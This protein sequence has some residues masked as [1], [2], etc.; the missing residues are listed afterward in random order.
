[1]T[2]TILLVEDNPITT[3]LVRFALETQHF[4]VVGVGDGASAIRAFE[5][6]AVG[7]VLVDLLLPDMDGFELLARL[8][9]LRG[10]TEVPILAF[11]GLVSREIEE[12]M[13]AAGF[14]DVIPKPI[15]PSRFV[16]VVRAHLPP[17]PHAEAPQP[18]ARRLRIVIADDDAVQRKLVA[19]RLRR[20][21]Y[22][23]VATM[24]GEEALA[25]AKEL[26]PDAVVSDV[27]MPRLDGFGL[28]LAVR[29]DPEIASTPVVLVTNSYLESEDCELARRVGANDLVIRTPELTEVLATLS[30]TIAATTPV[31]VPVPIDPAIERERIQRMM[32]QLERQVALG[33]GSNQRTS[34]L[35]AELAVLTAIADA[36]A[37]Q[38]D[39][40]V[41][42]RQVLAACFDA[43]GVSLGALYLVEARKR[44]VL[45][46]GAPG[47]WTTAELEGFFGDRDLLD[48]AIQTQTLLIAPSTESGPRGRAV[49][50]RAH[51]KSLLAAPLANMGKPLG[52]LVM[53]SRTSSL[54]EAD[55]ITFARAVAAQISLVLALARAFEEKDASARESRSQATVL[56]SIL[57]SMGDGVLVAGKD[58]EITHWNAAADGILPMSPARDESWVHRGVFGGDK[59]TPVSPND[60]P[61]AKAMRGE[62]IN[63]FE[64]FVRRD[65][66]DGAW[67]SV[68]ARPMRDESGKTQGG[69][70]VFR[71]VTTE[72]AA[73]ARLLVTDRMASLGILAAGVGHEI[74]NPL[75]SILAN[76]EMA[77]K[78]MS[79]LV[80]DHS[81]LDFGQLPEELRDARDAAERLRHIVRDLK[82]FS[83]ADEETRGKVDVERV[84]ESSI[85]LVSAEVRHRAKLVRSFVRLPAVYA[86]ESRLGQVFVN[87]L[88]NAAHAIPEGRADRNEIRV[89][90]SVT[91]DERV[92]IAITDTGTGMP[93]DVVARIFTP[94][95]TTKPVGVGTG[96]G[97]AICHQL[98]AAIDGEITLDTAV[99]RG[100]TF[101]VTLPA[102]TAADA[103]RPAAVPN[104]TP[105]RRAHILVIDDDHLITT[106]VERM[107]GRE[108]DVVVVSDPHEARRRVASGERYDVLLC[109]LM[110]PTGTGM[111]LHAELVHIAPDQAHNM[112]FMTGGAFT[113][114]AREFLDEVP[115]PRMEK[116]F[117]IRNLR[118]MIHDRLSH[119][120]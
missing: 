9:L 58:G 73:N 46:F 120:E 67:F 35:T 87:L 101:Y 70:A 88:V 63:G 26:R 25:R 14:D 68:N 112:V 12:R 95:Y 17:D 2:A 107:L 66:T 4:T 56:R 62:S 11:T 65:A 61:L 43:G 33:A 20:A 82:L 13:S 50:E 79:D 91:A 60:F 109:D 5:D 103:G 38:R 51:V 98:V 92:R 119:R 111:D 102:M 59:V 36:V 31:V 53:V 21:G 42:L 6:H 54:D 7:L 24:D 47:A 18:A 114:R 84:L 10:G 8:R 3:K 76:L 64:L 39:V 93:P 94:F 83:R 72:K 118:A 74:N 40:E 23:V 78:D 30:A 37:N 90:T 100:T 77:T 108:H 116:P 113:S 117:S 71:D 96:L 105:P 45:S 16:K 44:R 69:V 1:M 49:L 115:N 32:Q 52:A 29:G 34:L 22:D 27:L 106:T 41:A 15:E 110:M 86:N 80:R 104:I 28:C 19:M 99:G 81:A 55:H 97:L 89:A 75:Q 48:T 85:R 57:D